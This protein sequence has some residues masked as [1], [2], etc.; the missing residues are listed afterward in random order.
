MD[1]LPHE[2]SDLDG[3]SL[4]YWKPVETRIGEIPAFSSISW[5]VHV[6]PTRTFIR[7]CSHWACGVVDSSLK[8]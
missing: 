3:D 5:S 7:T 8:W 4:T 1:T 6:E 2:Q